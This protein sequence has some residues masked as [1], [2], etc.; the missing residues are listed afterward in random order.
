MK[1]LGKVLLWIFAII[2]ILVVIFTIVVVKSIPIRKKVVI[3]PNTYLELSLGGLHHDYNEYE[4]IFFMKEKLSI[5]E[6]CRR[7][8]AAKQDAH[9]SR[10]T[11]SEPL[12]ESLTNYIGEIYDI[13]MGQLA[14]NRKFSDD[15]LKDIMEER[16][17]F[18]I[19]GQT[20]LDLKLVDA[21]SYENEF[22][23]VMLKNN[24]LVNFEDYTK[25]TTTFSSVAQPNTITG[26]IGVVGLVPNWQKL[27]EWADINTY[28]IKRGK[29]ATFFS[30]N[31]APSADDKKSLNLT[32]EN[33]Y[34]AFKEK[35]AKNRNM[36]L[37]KV[38]EVAQGRIWTGIDAVENGL[39]D[40]L[41]GLNDAIAKAAELAHIKTYSVFVLPTRKGLLDIIREEKLFNIETIVDLYLKNVN[42]NIFEDIIDQ[43]DLIKMATQEPVQLILPYKISWQ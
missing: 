11:I 26:S 41:G 18:L 28:Q 33:V 42:P 35:V 2:G 24:H 4:G 9:I 27:R 20:A 31:F 17:E 7:L 6:I 1:T 40:E 34:R 10:K 39:V 38:E 30:P 22:K 3:E 12:R 43:K 15:K 32:M 29:Y 21:L 19:S 5:G 16:K 23:D 14:K 13:Y 8:D 37:S 36:S 25:K